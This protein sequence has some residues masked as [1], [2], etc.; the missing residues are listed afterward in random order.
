[1]RA[2]ALWA[3]QGMVHWA[4]ESRHHGAQ[5]TLANELIGIVCDQSRGHGAAEQVLRTQLVRMLDSTILQAD[6]ALQ[7]QFVAHVRAEV[8][9]VCR[10]LTTP[11]V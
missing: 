7:V 10:L 6:P 4:N 2:C 1:M 5:L 9:E 11:G 8:V 3:L